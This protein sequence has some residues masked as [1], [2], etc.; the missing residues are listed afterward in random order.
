MF[1][2]RQKSS[3]N[4]EKYSAL[5]EKGQNYKVITLSRKDAIQSFATQ[6]RVHGQGASAPSKNMVEMQTLSTSQLLSQD[7]YLS[8]SSYALYRHMGSQIYNIP[9]NCMQVNYL[10]AFYSWHLN[11]LFKNPSINQFCLEKKNECR[12]M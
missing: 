5:K 7:L 2:C 9:Q 10:I 6:S 12:V 4:V 11:K 8:R 3:T 1:P